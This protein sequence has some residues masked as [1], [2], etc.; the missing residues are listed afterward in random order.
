MKPASIAELKKELNYRSQEQLM[1]YCLKLARFKLESKELLTYLIFE[2]E[3]EAAYIQSVKD[4]ITAQFKEINTS[5]FY[6]VKKSV[7]KILRQT[8]RNIRYSKKAETEAELLIFF[9]NE[10]AALRPSIKR[11]R[12]LTNMY[13]KQIEF[14]QRAIAKLHPDLQYDLQIEL[15]KLPSF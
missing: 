13:R 2:S 11:N 1:D 14:A 15:Q 8:K 7:R 9:C 5:S 10:L 3:N 4:Y 6:F 12:V